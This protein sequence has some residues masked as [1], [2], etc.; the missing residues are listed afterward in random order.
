MPVSKH[1]GLTYLAIA[2]DLA[3]QHADGQFVCFLCHSTGQVATVWDIWV[4]VAV[5]VFSVK[6]LACIVAS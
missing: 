3:R 5:S 1:L 2:L 6:C 4:D